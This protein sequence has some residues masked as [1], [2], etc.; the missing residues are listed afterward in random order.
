M[1]LV[2]GSINVDLVVPV[3]RLPLPGETVLGGDYALLPGG[4]GANQALAARR[5]GA[6]VALIGA[7]GNDPFAG[8]A[9]DPLRRAGIDTGLVRIAEQP[10]GCA[11]VIVAAGGGGT[12]GGENAI[13]VA[14][15]ANMSV[16][17]DQIP[18]VL[19]GPG[20]ILVV[21]MEIPAVETA[22]ALRRARARGG[23]S[24]LNLAP[25][26]PL[27]PAVLPQIDLL[28]SNQGEAA[29]LASD[30]AAFARSLRQGLVVT[31]GAAG[32]VAYLA[33]GGQIEVPALPIEPVDTTGA[34]DTFVGVL[35]AAL[36]RRLP[37]EAA[38]RR[39]SAAAGLACLAR[40]AQTA[41]PDE[42]AI[43][44]ATARLASPPI[45]R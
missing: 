44:Q 24:L 13:A 9:L 7:V 14:P 15:G 36:D 17:A 4:K 29:I 26:L 21:Q 3:A 37:L 6:E 12:G 45:S 25:A 10:T 35:A 23:Y 11:A 22:A 34:G 2:F 32:A 33:D 42:A 18:D 31:R 38:L 20:A 28:V 40:G 8:V 39:A 43:V 19:L 1:I 30:P 5:A 41:M 27:D 16:R